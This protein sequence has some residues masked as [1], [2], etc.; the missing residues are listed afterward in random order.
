[1]MAARAGDAEQDRIERFYQEAVVLVL[2]RLG[3]DADALIAAMLEHPERARR[4][5]P[6]D[7]DV[8]ARA[9]D[10]QWRAHVVQKGPEDG[11]Y[12]LTGRWPPA[13]R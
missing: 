4:G 12:R 8:A 6:R 9:L 10:D 2:K 3:M 5:I 7:P 1:M 13:D 11:R